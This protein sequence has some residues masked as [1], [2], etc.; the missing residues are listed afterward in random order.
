[1]SQDIPSGGLRGV[2]VTRA[3]FKK[4]F[5]WYGRGQDY[6]SHVTTCGIAFAA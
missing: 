2:A 4:T 6:A 5:F 1:M 3:R